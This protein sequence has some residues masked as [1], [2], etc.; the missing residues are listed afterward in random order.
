MGTWQRIGQV[1]QAVA[2]TRPAWGWLGQAALVVLGTHLA[3]DSLDDVVLD[4]LLWLPLQWASPG[5]ATG[6]A[7]WVAIVLELTVAAWVTT[8]LWAALPHPLATWRHV[9]ETI[10]AR[11]IVLTLFWIPIAL[12]GS[13]VISMAVEDLLA[14]VHPLLGAGV[15]WLVGAVVAWRLGWTGLR[16]VL[17]SPRPR[18]RFAGVWIAPVLLGLALLAASELPVWGWWPLLV[19][20]TP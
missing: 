5:D 12:A 17:S 7:V 6:P 4:V 1:D 3:C 15:G 16:R 18:S 10:S 13:W 8:R 2:S 14:T 9:R 20:G 19:G 11:S